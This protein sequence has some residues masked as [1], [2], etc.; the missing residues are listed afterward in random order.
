[1]RTAVRRLGSRAVGLGSRRWPSH[2]RLF[3]VGENADWVIAREMEQVGR[4]ASGLGIRL[5]P[6]RLGRHVHGQSLFFGSQFVLFDGSPLPVANRL[7]VA[8]FHGRPGTPGMPEFDHCYAALRASHPHVQRVQVSHSEMRE[9][10]LSTGI[11][12]AKVRTIPIGI[13]LDDFPARDEAGR[14]AARAALGIPESAVVV[15]SIQK[16]GVGWGDGAEPKLI[17]G[18]DVFADAMER[19]RERVPE[20]L[21]LLGGPARGYVKSR[22]E[23]AGIPYRHVVAGGLAEVG[24]LFRALDLY[25][26]ASRQEGGPKA[27]F[28]SWATGVPLVSTRVGQAMDLV[29]HGVNGW[30]ADVEDVEGLVHW[31]EQALTD[32]ATAAAVTARARRDVEL[33][34]YRAQ[35]PLWRS[36]F[37]GFV[38]W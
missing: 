3:L 21:V 1:M 38:A 25:L 31:A 4:V 14:R 37:E 34:G 7:G 32:P 5:G 36:F 16:D 17:K 28:E 15:G 8:Y 18:P 6:A 10:V 12:P 11:D 33:H 26:V 27:V 30:L 19:L 22:L 13:D 23:A 35:A 20:L 29:E 9:I 24:E 2:S